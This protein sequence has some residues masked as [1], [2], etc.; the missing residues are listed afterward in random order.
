MRELG[1]LPS[2]LFVNGVTALEGA[3]RFTS[4]LPPANSRS[5]VVGSF[6]WDPFAA[7]LPFDVTMVRQDVEGLIAEVFACST[8]TRRTATAL[9]VVPTS[10]GRMG[11]L[12]GAQED[13]DEDSAASPEVSAPPAAGIAVVSRAVLTPNNSADRSWPAVSQAPVE[14]LAA[15]LA[16]RQKR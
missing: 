5:V 14:S 8:T 16:C 10:F 6:D 3:L 4:T 13:W 15:S 12:D 9:V 2:G 7:H 1:R 11:E